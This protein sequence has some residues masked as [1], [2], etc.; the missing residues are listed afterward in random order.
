[1][2][3]AAAIDQ[4]QPQLVHGDAGNTERW[5]GHF[6]VRLRLDIPWSWATSSVLGLGLR[7]TPPL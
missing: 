4:G 7:R 3:S 2:Y 5:S 1:M 6:S